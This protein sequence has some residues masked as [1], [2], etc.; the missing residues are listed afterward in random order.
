MAEGHGMTLELT[1]NGPA[2]CEVIGDGWVRP[3][4]A[5]LIDEKFRL[6]LVLTDEADLSRRLEIRA[7]I[8][9]ACGVADVA[10]HMLTILTSTARSVKEGE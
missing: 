9:T 7:G 6:T 1:P 2:Q 10:K 5:V 3:K 4:V 8:E